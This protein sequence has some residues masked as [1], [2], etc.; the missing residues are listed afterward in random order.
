MDIR[1]IVLDNLRELF[2]EDDLQVPQ[3]TDELVLLDTEL[4]SLGFAV[5]VTRL[6]EQLGYDPFTLMDE[7]YYPVTLGDLIAVYERFADHA[8]PAG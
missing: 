2:E 6:E 4:D 5:L 7:G 1:S 3:F 8:T